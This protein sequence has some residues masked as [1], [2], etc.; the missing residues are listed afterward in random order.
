MITKVL[1]STTDEIDGQNQAPSMAISDNDTE[2]I[3]SGE[4]KS[5]RFP[6]AR[7]P[8]IESDPN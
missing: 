6:S 5:E 3:Q 8:K 2:I 1:L 7:L 4:K